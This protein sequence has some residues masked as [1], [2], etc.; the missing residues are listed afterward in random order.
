MRIIN[1]PIGDDYRVVSDARNFIL[2]KGRVSQGDKTKGEMQ[3]DNISY[4]GK[5][6]GALNS[7]K[8]YKIKE[9]DATSIQML[10]RDVG[11]IQAT[12]EQALKGV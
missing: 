5:L 2:Q 9:S 8:D 4:H 6:E 11:K 10:L 3:W 12:I 7:C 1:I